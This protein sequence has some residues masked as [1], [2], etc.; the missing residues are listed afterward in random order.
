MGQI[1]SVTE[2]EM[3]TLESKRVDWNLLDFLVPW[4]PPA[5]WTSFRPPS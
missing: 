5:V 1:A 2:T 4:T 3:V